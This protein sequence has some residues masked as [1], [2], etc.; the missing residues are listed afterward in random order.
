[1]AAISKYNK[2]PRQL[3][4]PGG[5]DMP[6]GQ[7]KAVVLHGALKDSSNFQILPDPRIVY[8]REKMAIREAK[9]ADYLR[10]V[11]KGTQAFEQV[12]DAR[13]MMDRYEKLLENVGDTLRD[14]LKKVG[15][16]VRDSIRVLMEVYLDP[17]NQKGLEHLTQQMVDRFTPSLDS[18]SRSI[19][20]R[21]ATRTWHCVN[22]TPSA[23]HRH[24]HQPL[25]RKRMENLST[26][27]GSRKSAPQRHHSET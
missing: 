5:P 15:K 20:R 4:I 14:S 17:R 13:E 16:P 6:P 8:D 3:E 10:L 24:P 26:T 18:W 25:P 22:S 23:A 2:F 1:M 11:R 21:V 7:Y 27:H 9:I 19:R 12:R